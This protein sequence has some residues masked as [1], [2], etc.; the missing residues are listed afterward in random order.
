MENNLPDSSVTIHSP[1]FKN[2]L[3]PELSNLREALQAIDAHTHTLVDE[4]VQD[5]VGAMVTGNT[6]AGIAVTYDDAG[7][8][9]NF[10]AQTAGDARYAP[11][12]KGVTNGDSHDHNGGDGGPIAYSSL[13]G[14]PTIPTQEN[15]EDYVGAMV[16]GNTEAGIAVTYDDAGG[17]LNFDAQ[18]AG[19]AR[20]TPLSG[21]IEVSDS[22]SYASAA[23][24]TIPTD[25]TTRYQKA[26]KIRLKQGG[27]YKYYVV[28]S[29]T[30]TVITVIVSTD[31]TVANSA[32]TD[33]AYS[34]IENPYGFPTQFSFVPTWTN[35]TLGNGSENAK[36]SVQ[37]GNIKGHIELTF[38]STS[39]ISGAVSFNAPVNPLDYAINLREP[40]G[41]TIFRDASPSAANVGQTIIATASTLGVR[42]MD[43]SGTYGLQV[44]ISSTIPFTWTT[45]DILFV[46]FDYQF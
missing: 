19:D 16:T 37:Q 24:I 39:S 7:G 4:D 33:I 20:Y 32:I 25:G 2:V 11:I 34:F 21:W 31:Y 5:I 3:S 18:T 12:A 10:D 23:T 40:I 38:G 26:M 41:T 17:K 27:G 13:T 1:A 46:S 29:L 30:A 28:A 6:E 15:I 42:I 44:N 36:W 9:L 35:L 8:K 14:T 45:N 43:S 22:W